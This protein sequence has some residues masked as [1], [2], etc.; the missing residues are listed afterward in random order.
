MLIIFNIWYLRLYFYS[1]VDSNI[2]VTLSV[3]TDYLLNIWP[4]L[5]CSSLSNYLWYCCEVFRFGSIM[6]QKSENG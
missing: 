1:I 6:S 3:I 4:N 5:P 2:S